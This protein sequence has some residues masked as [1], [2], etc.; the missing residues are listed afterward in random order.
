MKLNLP[1]ILTLSRIVVIPIFILIFYFDEVWSREV[2]TALFV[3]A[4]F[5]DWYD[6]HLARKYGQMTRFGAFLDPVADKLMVA[7]ALVLLVQNNPTML[8]AI[9]AAVIIGREIAISALRE[10]MSEIGE[11]TRVAVSIIGKIKTTAQMTAILL[12]IYRLPLGP[13]PTHDIGLFLLYVAA[14]LTLWSMFVY[15]KA[16][17]PLLTGNSTSNQ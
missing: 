2:C 15:M 1:I 13:F 4:A 3:L 7:V 9:P 17:W 11:R 10:W 6:G 8:F 12:L 14:I 16:A 5:T